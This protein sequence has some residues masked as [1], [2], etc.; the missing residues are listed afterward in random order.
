MSTKQC[1][2]L[3]KSAV[4]F[5]KTPAKALRCQAFASAA[6]ICLWQLLRLLILIPPQK[7]K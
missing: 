4:H 1:S 5:A 6:I 2:I 3:A 7:A